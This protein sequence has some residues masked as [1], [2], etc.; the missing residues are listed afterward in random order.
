MSA[1]MIIAV[2]EAGPEVPALMS[3]SLALE[4]LAVGTST[5]VP[6]IPAALPLALIRVP[7]LV[8][9]T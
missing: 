8:G 7:V 5:L 2:V 1:L 9:L 6:S 4:P 3:A